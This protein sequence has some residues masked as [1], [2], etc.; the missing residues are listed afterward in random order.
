MNTNT[1]LEERLRRHFAAERQ[2]AEPPSDIEARVRRYLEQPR[3]AR[4]GPGIGRQLVLAAALL[5][6]A[7][8]LAF[9]VARIREL[10][11]GPVGP[12][13]TATASATTTAT[14]I[15]SA[16]PSPIASP[17]AA[18]AAETSDMIAAGKPVAEQRLAIPDCGSA[19]PG[20]GHDCFTTSLG[21][22]DAFV[23][24]NAGYFHGS[25]FG[26]GCWVYLYLDAAGWHFLDVRCGQAV[27]SLPRVDQDDA[28][29]VSGCAN[30]RSQPS[31]QS[32]VLACVPN[33]TLVHIS[34]GLVYQDG[35]LWWLLQ[36]RGW[37]A[38]DSL[39]GG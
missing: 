19:S 27:G 24:P 39:V 30:I 9:G 3:P 33:G 14:V 11:H 12:T 34:G 38:H 13:P 21:G 23:G 8:G 5:L 20:A 10:N 28:V 7:A 35:H 1:D 32:Q 18:T 2:A 16:S 15:P 6:F 22:P 36:G 37:M 29:N 31:L 4:T 25:R 26:S 17:H